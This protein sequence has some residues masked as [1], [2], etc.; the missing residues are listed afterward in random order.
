MANIP[1]VDF[2]GSAVTRL[3]LGDNP[4]NG[5]SYI[6]DIHSG[7]EM[8]DYYTAKRVL[9]TLFLAEE[10]GIN[11]YVALADPFIL[12]VLRQYRNEGGKMQ[13][14]FQSYPPVDLQVN[15]HQM[16]AL[17]PIGIYH[18]G[19]TFDLLVEE[20]KT[21][22][23]LER[24]SWI[25]AS[26]VKAGFGTH[27]PET[28]L[29]AEQ[30]NWGVDFYMACLYNARRTQRGQQSGFITG[31]PKELVFYPGD[32]PLMYEV[33]RQVPKPCIAFKVFAGGQAFIGKAPEEIPGIVKTIYR[34]VFSNI[35]PGDTA[36]VGIFQKEK[37]QLKESADAVKEVLN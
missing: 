18:Q 30:E 21:E 29:R 28:I 10:Y 19:G 5:H 6:H 9:E 15:V 23:L 13:I 32:P 16:M 34:D 24:L 4:F 26:G 36:C 3:M 7:D 35:K 1:C 11:A 31:K 37:D 2:Y 12:R 22:E 27:E 20:E 14:I 33:I 17:D 25:R 8:L